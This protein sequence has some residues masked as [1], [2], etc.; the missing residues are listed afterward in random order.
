[1]SNTICKTLRKNNSWKMRRNKKN[2]WKN[3][4]FKNWIFD[5]FFRA[6]GRTNEVLGLFYNFKKYAYKI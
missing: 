5:F 3:K 4:L 6:S 2:I 1:M